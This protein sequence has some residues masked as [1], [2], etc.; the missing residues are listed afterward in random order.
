MGSIDDYISRT[1]F[2]Y[3]K[4]DLSSSAAINYLSKAKDSNTISDIKTV[5]EFAKANLPSGLSGDIDQAHDF[6]NAIVE[7]NSALSKPQVFQA[8]RYALTGSV[9]GIDIP[10]IFMLL[11]SEVSG[12]RLSAGLATF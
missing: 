11:G 1:Q 3:V 4:P 5:I 7:A 6:C 8:L 12:A 10:T 2:L 9:P